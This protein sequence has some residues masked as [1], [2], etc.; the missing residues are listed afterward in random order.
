M[1]GWPKPWWLFWNMECE[2]SY[3][4][5]IL[6][7]LPILQEAAMG[8]FLDHVSILQ[9]STK[10]PFLN[11]LPISREAGDFLLYSLRVGL[12]VIQLLS[13]N[14]EFV[15]PLQWLTTCEVCHLA[16]PVRC[17]PGGCGE[18]Y[19]SG[20]Y[21]SNNNI[22]VHLGSLCPYRINLY[23]RGKPDQQLV[24]SCCLQ[25]VWW[26]LDVLLKEKAQ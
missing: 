14:M 10:R 9:E 16:P 13:C 20:L 8:Q 12:R 24:L 5:Q 15:P 26:P 7:C 21:I 19:P 4:Q 1:A 17:H 3:E 11:C 22:S 6:L 25:N 18:P 23:T 2:W